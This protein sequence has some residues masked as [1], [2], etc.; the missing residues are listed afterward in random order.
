MKLNLDCIRDILLIVEEFD[1]LDLNNKNYMGYKRLCEYDYEELSYHLE[2][3]NLNGFFVLY[4]MRLDI[5]FKIV[6]LTPKGHE[7]ISNLRDDNFYNKVK[8][9]AIEL[10]IGSIAAIGDLATQMITKAIGM[11]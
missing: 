5:T 9:K 4:D 11:S 6:G 7:Y 3:C 8:K 1:D 10:G 2:Q